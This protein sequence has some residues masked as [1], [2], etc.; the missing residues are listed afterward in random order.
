M[1]V[2]FKFTP[3]GRGSAVIALSILTTAQAQKTDN[4]SDLTDADIP[5]FREKDARI[6]KPPTLLKRGSKMAIADGSID[7]LNI[8]LPDEQPEG[9]NV[10]SMA[11][12]VQFDETT[13]ATKIQVT[14]SQSCT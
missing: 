13:A 1:S 9:W 7:D 12:T 6:E 14:Y 11:I 3:V 2:P 8:A 5:P 4:L 10:T